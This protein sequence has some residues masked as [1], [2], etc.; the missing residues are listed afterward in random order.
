MYR[1]CDSQVGLFVYTWHVFDGRF[2]DALFDTIFE[3]KKNLTGGVRVAIQ[4]RGISKTT[5]R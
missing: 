4:K 3:K 1:Q 2:E 5:A